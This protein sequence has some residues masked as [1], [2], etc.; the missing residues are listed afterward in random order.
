MSDS[1]QPPGPY[2]RNNSLH[3]NGVVSAFIRNPTKL[4]SF[5]YS[6]ERRNGMHG[7]ILIANIPSEFEVSREFL[8]QFREVLGVLWDGNSLEDF[9]NTVLG[10]RALPRG[11]IHSGQA[12]DGNCAGQLLTVRCSGRSSPSSASSS[13]TYRPEMIGAHSFKHQIGDC[14]VKMPQESECEMMSTRVE[15]SI[16]IPVPRWDD[17]GERIIAHRNGCP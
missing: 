1:K 4:K 14:F 3:K 6:L 5:L 16:S 12:R 17:D 8:Q 15:R 10:L 13:Q 7:R 11:D 9:R 2:S